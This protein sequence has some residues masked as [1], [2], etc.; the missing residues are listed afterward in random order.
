M[1]FYRVQDICKK[2]GG[3]ARA[4]STVYMDRAEGLLPEPVKLG[5]RAVGFPAHEVDQVM[6]ARAA[7]ATAEQIKALVKRLMAQRTKR[8]AELLSVKGA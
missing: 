7:G 2:Y 5:A 1:D 3:Q 4:R 6:E 8:L